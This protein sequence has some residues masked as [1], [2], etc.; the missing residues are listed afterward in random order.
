MVAPHAFLL[1]LGGGV[2]VGFVQS[3]RFA[4][5]QAKHDATNNKQ[6]KTQMS[7]QMIVKAT[8]HK[9]HRCYEN[10]CTAGCI[11]FETPYM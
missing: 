9:V 6:D 10:G 8:L 1:A 7:K 5:G 3:Q 11:L 4:P 2:V